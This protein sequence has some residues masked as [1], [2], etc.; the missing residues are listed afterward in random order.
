MNGRPW[1]C[2]MTLVAGA[3]VMG[4]L[5]AA[6]DSRGMKIRPIAEAQH[7]GSAGVFVGV[8]AFDD[9]QLPALKCAVNDA[10]AQTHLFVLDLRLIPAANC[11]LLMSGNPSTT[12]AM[13]ELDELRRAGVTMGEAGRAEILRAVTQ[14]VKDGQGGQDL[15]VSPSVPMGFKIKASPTPCPKM[16]RPM[17]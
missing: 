14:A 1:M 4:G 8:N 7:T 11:R 5:F 12:N 13:V 3:L 2:G 15:L 16:V 17:I 6:D 10:I 9:R